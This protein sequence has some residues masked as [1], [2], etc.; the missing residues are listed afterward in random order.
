MDRRDPRHGP[1]DEAIIQTANKIGGLIGA[2]LPP[3]WGFA[4]LIFPF[5]ESEGR[6]NYISNANRETMLRSL[7][8]LVANMKANRA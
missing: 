2:S 4:L 3:Q 7:E 8:E 5:G 6:M 1:M